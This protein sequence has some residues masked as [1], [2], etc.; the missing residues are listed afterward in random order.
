MWS[1]AHGKRALRLPPFPPSSLAWVL[2]AEQDFSRGR[3][4]GKAFPGEGTA[5]AKP[6]VHQ[7]VR[8]TWGAACVL[9]ESGCGGEE[10]VWPGGSGALGTTVLEGRVRAPGASVGGGASCEVAPPPFVL[11]LGTECTRLASWDPNTRQGQESQTN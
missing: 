8:S 5:W 1:L 10:A 6:G 2:G 11:S 3:R 4:C 9:G 7:H